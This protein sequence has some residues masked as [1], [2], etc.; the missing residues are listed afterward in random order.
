MFQVKIET[1]N[2]QQKNKSYMDLELATKFIIRKIQ[3]ILLLFS[4]EAIAEIVVEH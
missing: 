1:M 4:D 2:K 3:T